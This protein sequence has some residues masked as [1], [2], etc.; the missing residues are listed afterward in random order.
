MSML[1]VGDFR[2]TEAWI[3]VTELHFKK[4]LQSYNSKP[5]AFLIFLSE[6][7]SGNASTVL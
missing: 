1:L 3:G 4:N 7:N 5:Q 2:W 6:K